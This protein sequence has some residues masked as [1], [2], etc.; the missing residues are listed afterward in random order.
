MLTAL[1]AR[2]AQMTEIDLIAAGPWILFG[3]ALAAVCL[4]LAR[5]RRATTRRN[6]AGHESAVHRDHEE[7]SCPEKKNTAGRRR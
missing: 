3:I 7:A 4:Q 5:S 2:T 6:P 1:A